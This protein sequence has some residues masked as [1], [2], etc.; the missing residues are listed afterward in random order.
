VLNLAYLVWEV[1]FNGFEANIL[2]SGRHGRWGE[3]GNVEVAQDVVVAEKKSANKE[4]RKG[5]LSQG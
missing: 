1:D 3:G 5:V 2:R 4:L